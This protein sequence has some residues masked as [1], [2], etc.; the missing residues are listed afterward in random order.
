MKVCVLNQSGS[1]GKST[2]TRE[3]FAPRLNKPLIIEVEGQNKSSKDFSKSGYYDVWVFDGNFDELYLKIIENEDVILDIGASKLEQFW[4]E[5]E[6]IAGIEMLFDYFV[7]PVVPSD[8]AQED[9]AK[10]IMFLREKGIE[11]EKI[12][13]IF[14]AVEN[15][16]EQEFDIF[17]K[18][19]KNVGF[20]VDTELFIRKN[21]VFNELG[22]MR[23]TLA[24][25]YNPDL[26]AYKEKIL[27]TKEPAK[28]LAYVKM[29]MANRM[30]HTAIDDL[31]FV[32]EKITGL[33][34]PFKERFGGEKPK[35]KKV[36]KTPKVKKEE[37]PQEEVSEDDEEL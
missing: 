23:K 6:K 28:K 22:L 3:L 8:K 2:I 35:N 29:D 36:E 30:G 26:N 1:V 10:T 34:S 19:L 7:V 21:K 5:L 12:K 32:F 31:D 11:D 25:V 15:S 33:K 13:V 16:V 37:I 20:N 4:Q 14:N 24:D 27:K 17:L 18:A 9:T